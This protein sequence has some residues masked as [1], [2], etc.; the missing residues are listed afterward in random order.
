[1]QRR[2]RGRGGALPRVI[3]RRSAD[4]AEAEHDILRGEAA[5][6]RRSEAR[7]VG[8]ELL[9]PGEAQAALREGTNEEG[10]MLVLALSYEDF[11]PDDEG[12]ECQITP[13]FW[14]IAAGLRGR[15]CACR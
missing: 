4:A 9:R 1:M 13:P 15:R 10:E 12:A 11:I 14:P 3:V 5:L 6:E 7:R 2:T 8:A